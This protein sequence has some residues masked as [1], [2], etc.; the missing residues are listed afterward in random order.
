MVVKLMTP[1]GERTAIIL[2]QTDEFVR[3]RDRYGEYAVPIEK[4]NEWRLA[5]L[6]PLENGQANNIN[7]LSTEKFS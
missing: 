2:S 4:F 1:W 5:A 3:Y 6:P 7:H